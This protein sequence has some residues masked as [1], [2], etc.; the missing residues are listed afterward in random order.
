MTS[1]SST[2]QPLATTCDKIN[3]VYSVLI[4]CPNN[5]SNATDSSLPWKNGAAFA[6]NEQPE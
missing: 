2:Q 6:L 3:L 1:Y 5:A 4:P